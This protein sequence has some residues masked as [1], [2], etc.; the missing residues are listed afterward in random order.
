MMKKTGQL[1]TS[2]W[3]KTSRSMAMFFSAFAF[4]TGV[5]LD[6]DASEKWSLNKMDAAILSSSKFADEFDGA[7]KELGWKAVKYP[8]TAQDWNS[9]KKNFGKYDLILGTP[10][11]FNA[12]LLKKGSDDIISD[13]KTDVSAL[14]E[15]MEKGGAVV[16]TGVSIPKQLEWITELNPKL[17]ISA[18][19]PAKKL[20]KPSIQETSTPAHALRCMPN[21]LEKNTDILTSLTLKFPAEWE[22]IAKN[23]GGK[24]CM[25]AKR[26]GKGFL[27]VSTLRHRDSD[28][29]QNLG[30]MLEL[31][32]MNMQ[33]VR[34]EH[35]YGGDKKTINPG[36]GTT[37]IFIKNTGAE[38]L[39]ATAVLKMDNGKETRKF[40]RTVTGIKPNA[41]GAIDISVMADM[42][43]KTM[44]ESALI[45]PCDNSSVTLS[46]DEMEFPEFLTVVPPAYRGMISETR[47]DKNVHF[48]IA[49]YPLYENIEGIQLKLTLT[50]SSG[51]IISEK[52]MT[53]QTE[54]FPVAMDMPANAPAGKYT[55]SAVAACGRNRYEKAKVDFK[56][57]PVRPGQVFIDQDTVI[58]KDGKPF[59]PLGIYHVSEAEIENAS[60]LGINMC[61]FWNWDATPEN[62]EHIAKA[63]MSIIWEGQAWGRAVYL[64]PATSKDE[65][66]FQKELAIMRDT[67]AKI[68]NNPALAMWYVG[69]EPSPY[70]LPSLKLINKTWHEADEDH[71][72]YLV[73]TGNYKEL[74]EASDILAIDCYLVYRGNRN[75]LSIVADAADNARKGVDFRK[76]VIAV[77]QAFGNNATHHEKPEDVRC[78]SYLYLTHGVRGM[79]W[80]CWK[81]TGDKTGEEGAGHHPATQE[82]LKELIKEIKVF[83]PALME[84]GQRMFKS[85]DGRIHAMLCGSDTTGKFLLLVNGA[86]EPSDSVLSVPEL[87]GKVT[88]D[89]LFGTADAKVSEGCLKVKMEP[90][91]TAVY[92]IK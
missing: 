77:P 19:T 3:K 16:L 69:D 12:I 1:F 42:R 45:N 14:R 13:R 60:K 61:Q 44:V 34:M 92:K 41:T 66:V 73:A 86:E 9:L 20:D 30:M 55:I 75:S 71:P 31:Q 79:M 28:F 80:Y 52:E 70:H 23:S 48:K 84:P 47:R 39:N 58:L 15:F 87:T 50:D 53:V 2:G 27:L 72:T 38:P 5:L 65:P 82:V 90:L 57:V 49:F 64:N 25:L 10:G 22:I 51:K 88:F 37:K 59:F 33:Y 11:A 78:M 83:A 62:L 21:A 76:P 7:L 81:E 40:T 26:F 35:A 67:A 89:R 24:P 8:D 32:R 54:E 63:G 4:C 46:K 91:A 56:V 6:A 18:E 43:G 17:E 29:M 36:R 85:Q 68:R 74:Q